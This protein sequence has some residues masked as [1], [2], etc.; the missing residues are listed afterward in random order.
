MV[1]SYVLLASAICLRLLHPMLSVL[2]LSHEL[3]YQL[4]VWASWVLPLSFFEIVAWAGDRA[5]QKC[6]DISIVSQ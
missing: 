1:R 3:T 6:A 5:R 4:S 2:A